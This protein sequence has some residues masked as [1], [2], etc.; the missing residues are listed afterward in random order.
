MS[1]RCIGSHTSARARRKRKNHGV[2]GGA[3][4]P[5]PPTRHNIMHATRNLSIS[6]L[7]G[8]RQQDTDDVLIQEQHVT[9]LVGGKQVLET[10]CSPGSLCELVYGHLLAVGAIAAPADVDAVEIQR[11]EGIIA[12]DLADG[13][14][15]P[16]RS[17]EP[18][19]VRGSFSVSADRVSEAVR[20]AEDHGELFRQTGGTHLA[21]IV[22][23]DS[24]GIFVE[25]ISRTCALEKVLGTALR[26][27]IDF[28][29][30][31][32]VVTSRV[33]MQFVVKAAHAGIPIIAAVS[34]PTYQAVEAADRLGICLC[35]FVRGERLNV[36]SQRWRI[37]LR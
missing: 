31:L 29:R 4:L 3:T 11:D 14:C 19:S 27:G 25:D 24:D 5:P 12:V 36:Y 33:P 18:E 7:E 28:G 1:R 35:G 15:V 10:D 2:G 13:I 21:A 32:L 26:R 20:S 6:R 8:Q 34:A 37:G 30:S 9:I 17:P 16:S 23:S 22:S